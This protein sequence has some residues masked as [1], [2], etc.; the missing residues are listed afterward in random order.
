MSFKI[1]LSKFKSALP[2]IPPMP[3]VNNKRGITMTP[4]A[5]T[6]AKLTELRKLMSEHDLTAYYV[7]SEDA[8]QVKRGFIRLFIYYS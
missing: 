7:P 1:I 3:L 8:H 6:T 2:R 4:S 5:C